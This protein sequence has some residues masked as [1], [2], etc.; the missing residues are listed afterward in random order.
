MA[1]AIAGGYM[2]QVVLGYIPYILGFLGT[3]IAVLSGAF[4]SHLLLST[5]KIEVYSEG[6]EYRKSRGSQ[7]A[8]SLKLFIF[9]NSPKPRYIRSIKMRFY[10]KDNKII[11][12]KSPET[13]DGIKHPFWGRSIADVAVD[14]ISLRSY[15]PKDIILHGIIENDEFVKL[16]NV[17]KIKLSYGQKTWK[18]KMCEID[19]ENKFS[20]NNDN[21]EYNNHFF[22]GSV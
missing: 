4:A 10:C 17:S 5:G 22:P 7:F 9:N 20:L 3:V 13:F 19:I 11:L 21:I 18:N 2:I 15:E 1:K 16:D 6:C 8:Y 14:K 12:E